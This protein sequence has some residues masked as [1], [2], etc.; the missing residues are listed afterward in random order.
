MPTLVPASDPAFRYEGRLDR[1]NP[2]APVVVWAGDRITVDFEGAELALRFGQAQG[3]AFFDVT[4]DGAT[5]VV[6]GGQARWVWPHRL[7]SG[8][9][10]LRIVKRSEADAGHVAFLG[11]ELDESGKVAAPSPPVYRLRIQ[12][13]G[14]SITV[15]ANNEDGAVD[16][17]EDRRT[18][19]HVL[20]YSYLTSQA[21][22]A[23]H[24][25]TAVSGMGIVEGFVPMIAGDTWNKVYPREPVLTADLTSWIPDLVFVNLGEN[26]DAFTRVNGR[27][28]PS[29]YTSGYVKL[30]KA[31]RAAWP[32]AQIVLLRG[33][34]WGGK[35]SDQLRPAW[36]KAVAELESGDPKITHYVF[37]HWSGQHPRVADHR[38]L[39][40][41]LT[42]WVKRQGFLKR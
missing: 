15:G 7:E 17:W 26:D 29:G 42:D 31:V 28:F 33:G 38:I 40:A 30:V 19:N 13:I 9:H 39:A 6:S 32:D 41:E 21:L 1:R 34:M 37:D 8:R 36:E 10:T 2:A 20:S 5:E 4:V 12:F 23:D 11:V 14:D 18:H 22:Q 25:A 35:N 3:Q 27:P 16:Q 24:R